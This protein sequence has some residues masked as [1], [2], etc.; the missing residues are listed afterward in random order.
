MA[1]LPLKLILDA[2]G[3]EAAKLALLLRAKHSHVR[4]DNLVPLIRRRGQREATLLHGLRLR[5][6]GFHQP[7]FRRLQIQPE[8]RRGGRH[9]CPGGRGLENAPRGDA[10]YAHDRRRHL[11]DLRVVPQRIQLCFG[12]LPAPLLLCQ[13]AVLQ[14]QGL[15]VLR[16]LL[17]QRYHLLPRGYQLRLRPAPPSEQPQAFGLLFLRNQTGGSTGALP[18]LQRPQLLSGGLQL[19]LPHIQLLSRVQLGRKQLLAQRRDLHGLA[20]ANAAVHVGFRR[21]TGRVLL[22]VQSCQR[23]PPRMAAERTGLRRGCFSRT[24]ERWTGLLEQDLL[25]EGFEHLYALSLRFR[26]GAQLCELSIARLEGRKRFP[27]QVLLLG[28]LPAQQ[29]ELLLHPLQ[30][31]TKGG[32]CSTKDS[33]SGKRW[34]GIL[35]HKISGQKCLGQKFKKRRKRGKKGGETKRGNLRR[36]EMID[37]H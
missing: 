20:L 11:D 17:A 34:S 18:A 1:P 3:F 5:I 4:N 30:L 33:L 26:G 14:L 6:P 21:A 12:V 28:A 37:R 27:V 25:H 36:F 8:R 29:L 19:S 23:Q 9:S 35:C 15:G 2:F 24:S 13:R 16:Q 22:P 7:R 10:W 32:D 31:A